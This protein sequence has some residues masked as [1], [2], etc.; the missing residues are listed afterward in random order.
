MPGVE[1]EAVGAVAILASMPEDVVL[2]S[3]ES[4]GRAVGGTTVAVPSALPPGH[5]AR[6][7]GESEGE[8]A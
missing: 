2:A 1:P 7:S 3:R 5:S 8:G 4:R 6:V